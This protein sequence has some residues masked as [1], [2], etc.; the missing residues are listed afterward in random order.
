MGEDEERV[1][2]PPIRADIL[3]AELKSSPV[4]THVKRKGRGLTNATTT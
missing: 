4:L 3:G 2:H 1:Y